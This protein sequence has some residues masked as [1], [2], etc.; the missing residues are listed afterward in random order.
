MIWCPIQE[1]GDQLAPAV[2][3]SAVHG[4][5]Q[6]MTSFEIRSQQTNW[7]DMLCFAML[8]DATL[9]RDM[10]W[11]DMLW[12]AMLLYD[13]TWHDLTWFDMLRYAMVWHL[14]WHDMT[15]YTFRHVWCMVSWVS[16]GQPTLL[17]TCKRTCT[18]MCPWTCTGP[19]TFTCPCMWTLRV[20][21]ST[22]PYAH[23]TWPTLIW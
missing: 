18:C 23:M 3:H 8:R 20:L 16:S 2:N 11:R 21:I 17:P 7:Y 13:M 15:W 14:I 5:H 4:G 19:C 9:W 22:A 10:L 6:L 1:V 12:H